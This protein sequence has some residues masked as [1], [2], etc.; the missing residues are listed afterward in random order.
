MAEYGTYT[1]AY[2]IRIVATLTAIRSKNKNY[3]TELLVD[4]QFEADIKKN[5][6]LKALYNCV[7]EPND[8]EY[9]KFMF[10]HPIMAKHLAEVR[11]SSKYLSG[12]IEDYVIAIKGKPIKM[13]I[14]AQIIMLF[15]P[16][17][18][19]SNYNWIHVVTHA[20]FDMNIINGIMAYLSPPIQII[21]K[22]QIKKCPDCLY[23]ALCSNSFAS[24]LSFWEYGE[25]P[26]SQAYYI[27]DAISPNGLEW[28]TENIRV[29]S[30]GYRQGLEFLTGDTET[31][32]RVLMQSLLHAI[33]KKKNIIFINNDHLEIFKKL[34]DL[35]LKLPLCSVSWRKIIVDSCLCMRDLSKIIE[36][37]WLKFPDVIR[38]LLPRILVWSM[39][40]PYLESVANEIIQ[41]SPSS[42]L[43]DLKGNHS[44]YTLLHGFANSLK[45]VTNTPGQVLK[46]IDY[47]TIGHG[48]VI[49]LNLSYFNYWLI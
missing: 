14:I 8:E 16:E 44:G 34:A 45:M 20:K 38:D 27:N 40:M 3:L 25:L 39:D 31:E 12:L 15:K 35:G 30:Q 2:D 48:M 46:V 18:L 13:E 36:V 19:A 21:Y 29:D 6:R 43:N 49:I 37:V 32:K 4:A 47:L 9:T 5:Y 41:R 7:M 23:S 28:L 11:L 17:E 33:E 24:L 1:G 10:A 42:I 26:T 22:A